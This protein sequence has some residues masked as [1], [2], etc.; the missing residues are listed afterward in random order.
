VKPRPLYFVAGSL[1]D[2]QRLPAEV[3]QAFGYALHLAQLGGR[4]PAAKALTGFSGGSVVEIVEDDEGGT[5]RVMYTVK[6]K[7]AVFVLHA[8]QKKSKRGS[9]TPLAEMK[10]VKARLKLAEVAHNAMERSHGQDP[11]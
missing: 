2:L 9:A 10:L 3:R 7:D 8:F 5:Y 1:K 4:H 11:N 6:F